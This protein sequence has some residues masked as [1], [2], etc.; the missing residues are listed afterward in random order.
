MTLPHQCTEICWGDE[1]PLLR[2][3]VLSGCCGL[4]STSH[5]L[6]GSA[7]ETQTHRDHSHAR[8]C[9]NRTRRVS[10]GW[11][12]LNPP[13]G[14]APAVN[15]EVR[16]RLAGEAFVPR[17][18]F[19]S[20][21]SHHGN[22][23]SGGAATVIHGAAISPRSARPPPETFPSPRPYTS[24]TAGKR[25]GRCSDRK[26][27]CMMSLSRGVVG[28]KATRR[29]APFVESAGFRV[30]SRSI[31]CQAPEGKA[32]WSLSAVEPLRD[33]GAELKHPAGPA[34]TSG[35]LVSKRRISV[36]PP[37]AVLRPAQTRSRR[38]AR[39]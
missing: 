29:R 8:C 22:R 18:L 11:R 19:L 9:R 5:N 32:R 25:T 6:R 4:G 24:R 3:R 35:F 2:V 28:C 34:V 21:T 20:T 30:L 17:A 13:R 7:N 10:L 27:T 15:S 33:M 31:P 16:A 39:S 23:R 14:S 12:I 1:I 37:I 26:R 36:L 38:F